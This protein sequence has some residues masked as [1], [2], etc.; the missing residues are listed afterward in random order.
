MQESMLLS[1]NKGI[2]LPGDS[3]DLEGLKSRNGIY[4]SGENEYRS[5]FFG[6]VQVGEEFVDVVSF[7]GTYMPRRGDKVVGKIIE[8]GPSMWIVDINSPYTSLL[9]INDCPWRVSSGDLKRFMKPG[10]YVYAKIMSMNEIKESW[11]TLKDVGLRKLE[12]GSVISIPPPKVPRIIGKGGSMV[13]MIKDST[14]TR[15]MVGQNGHIWVDGAPENI[16]VAVEA[17][18][19]VE[20]EAHTTGLTDRVAE[21]LKSRK[22]E[23]VGN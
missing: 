11:I 10:D 20:T 5:E 22:G 17:I 15:I 7:A 3:V 9:H 16:S 18:R 14:Q 21:F 12:G 13:N 6:V 23:T 8:I 2:V 1:K 4:K 19:L